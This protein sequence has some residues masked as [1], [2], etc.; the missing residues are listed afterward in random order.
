MTPAVTASVSCSSAA[1]KR[2]RRPLARASSLP[3]CSATMSPGAQIYGAASRRSAGR[4]YCSDTRRDDL[5][6]KTPCSSDAT[7]L[8]FPTAQRGAQGRHGQQLQG[9][10]RRG[11]GTARPELASLVI[12]ELHEQPDRE[13]VDTTA[14]II[15]QCQPQA[16]PLLMYATTAGWDR[17]LNLLRGVPRPP[18]GCATIRASTA[19]FLPVIYEAPRTA[20]L[21]ER[22]CVASCE[23]ESGHQRLNRLLC[24]ANL[25]AKGP[26]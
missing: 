7:R 17:Q 25:R 20:G 11:K 15:C 12:D 24:V 9:P 14:D 1:E 22:G 3:F 18:A 19:Y 16:S 8:R 10:E 21:D 4:R 13:L 6:G 2:Q 5:P 23:P 26:H